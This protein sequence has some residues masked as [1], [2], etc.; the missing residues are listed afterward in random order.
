MKN[1]FC[2]SSTFIL[3]ATLVAGAPDVRV[4]VNAVYVPPDGAGGEGAV[5]A[6]FAVLDPRIVVNETPPPRLELDPGQ[7]ILIDRQPP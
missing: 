2:L 7:A 1:R 6:R 5:E 4:R 3:T